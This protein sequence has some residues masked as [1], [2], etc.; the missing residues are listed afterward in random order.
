MYGFFLIVEGCGKRGVAWGRPF[1]S[2]SL[3]LRSWLVRYHKLCDKMRLKFTYAFMHWVPILLTTPPAFDINYLFLRLPQST[4]TTAAG[5]Q[6]FT[7]TS[8]VLL[9]Q[10]RAVLPLGGNEF[11]IFAKRL[12]SN[13]VRWFQQ[14]GGCCKVEFMLSYGLGIGSSLGLG[15]V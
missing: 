13:K 11:P 3:N 2:Y 6:P 8:E 12:F 10:E 1:A 15:F 7:R 4:V 9:N 14:N 5:I